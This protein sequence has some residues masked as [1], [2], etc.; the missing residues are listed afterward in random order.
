MTQRHPG[1]RRRDL[2][3][4]QL[5]GQRR[6]SAGRAVAGTAGGERQHRA[7]LKLSPLGGAVPIGIAL[8]VV[9]G[10]VAPRPWSVIGLVAAVAVFL[11]AMM[12]GMDAV[13]RGWR[14][15]VRT[16]DQG[17]DDAP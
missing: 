1:T 13:P 12:N 10:V 7:G 6:S 3:S 17:R 15:A 2:A 16:R 9:A 14:T 8:G 5:H 11:A 4:A